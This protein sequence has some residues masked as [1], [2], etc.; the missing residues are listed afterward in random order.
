MLL[1]T[2]A[3]RLAL[4]LELSMI[5]P[6]FHVS[7]LR[8]YL[9]NPSHVLAPH[10]IQLDEGLTYEEEPEAIIDRQVKK[11]H[12]KEVASMKVIQKN[13]LEDE[14]TQEAEKAMQA[15]YLHL[16]DS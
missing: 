6:V 5:H 2:V 14:A 9:P 12:S 11:L 4:P 13:H 1:I 3:Y 15:N 8:K 10:I 16:F 7:I